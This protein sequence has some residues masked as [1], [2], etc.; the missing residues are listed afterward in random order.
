MS[1][2]AS[3]S[4]AMTGLAAT[5]KRAETVSSNVANAST[6][7]YGRRV[8]ELAGLVIGG[9]GAG[10]T[11][12]DVRR[13]TDSVLIG[14]RRLADAGLAAAGTEAAGLGR[15]EQSI[16]VPDIPGSL[17]E[18]VSALDA[19]LIA[20]AS[21][22]ES[23]VRQAG[24]LDAAAGVAGKLN[25][26]STTIQ[27]VRM[28]ADA[29]IASDVG[30]L[31]DTLQRIEFLNRQIVRIEA[32]TGDTN[33]LQ[34]QRQ[35][36]IDSI[37]AIVPIRQVD[38]Q[39][40]QVA[41]FTPGG[42]VLLDGSAREVSFRPTPLITPQ[43][44]LASGALSGLEIDGRPVPLGEGGPIAGGRLAANFALRDDQA[45]AIQA[46]FDGFAR[47]LVERFQAADITLAPGAP[48]L[49]TDAGAPFNPTDESGLAARISV[50][51]L[52][53]PD[54][55]GSLSRLRDGLGAVV[56]GLP[57]AAQGLQALSD[58]LN[59][60]SVPTSAALS[61]VARTVS[62]HAAD[63]LSGVARARV[64]A[65]AEEGFVAARQEALRSRELEGG[66][67]TDA[68]MAALLQVEQAFA[69]N[70]RVLQA[71]DEML[72]TLLRR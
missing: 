26:I 51:A 68:E 1:L 62:G 65:D 34:D 69:A 32:T 58:A 47:D 52:A 10:V 41:L 56:P 25:E 35:A 17:G 43:M 55:G 27:T 5:S 3:L 23:E 59:T 64:S 53:D 42:A 45:P 8:V 4:T 24:V 15:I 72:Q 21:L 44:S 31:N 39:D 29:A 67:D 16:G 57:G 19:A 37:A 60:A 2:S 36:A 46:Q 40:G 28:E 11:V 22:P 48:G 18:R 33:A 14:D 61:G 30:L 20:A 9:Q 50:N 70:A 13:E 38:R 54:Q 12:I 7:G 71:V 66:V 63:I 49:F 6:P